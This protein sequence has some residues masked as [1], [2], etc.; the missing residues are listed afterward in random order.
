M[1]Y[2]FRRSR[3]AAGL[4]VLLSLGITAALWMRPRETVLVPLIASVLMLAL[5]AVAARLLGNVLAGMENTRYLGYLHMELDPEKFLEHYAPVPQRMKGQGALIAR[6]Y[7][8]DGYWAAGAYDKALP[9]LQGPLP[10]PALRGL[11]CARRAACSLAMEDTGLAAQAL[12]ELSGVIDGCRLERPE[13]AANLQT[14][15]TIYRQHLACLE[16]KP[17]DIAWLEDAFRAAQYN[18]RRLEIQK[19]LALAARNAGDEA[20]ARKALTYLRKEGGKTA[21]KTWADRQ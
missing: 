19:V 15:L 3:W 17:A 16:G 14:E 1:I 13:L 11:Y 2:G 6:A 4:V 18:I 7:L 20:A 12:E 21:F 10:T 9:L 5:G 8:A